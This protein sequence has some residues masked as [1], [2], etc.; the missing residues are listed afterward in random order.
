MINNISA[1]NKDGMHMTIGE[2]DTTKNKIRLYW[3]R[4]RVD[5]AAA[6]QLSMEKQTNKNAEIGDMPFIVHY[7][8]F[9]IPEGAVSI[10]L[11]DKDF[12]NRYECS[13]E[14]FLKFKS[15]DNSGYLV[16]LK[17]FKRTR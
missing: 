9:T 10:E 14:T 1:P 15:S 5:R 16:N 12:D 4:A 13:L 8:D 3:S 11:I 17:D 7:P 2:Y 6:A